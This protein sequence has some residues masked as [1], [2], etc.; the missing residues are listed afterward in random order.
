MRLSA[1][2]P[3]EASVPGAPEGFLYACLLGIALGA[4]YDIFRILRVGRGATGGDTAPV[5]R[6]RAYR[7]R[8]L[9]H[10]P[11]RKKKRTGKARGRLSVLLVFFEDILFC[12]I[13]A[14]VTTLFFFDCN[15]GVIRWYLLMGLL[16]GFCAY[17]FSVGKA[18]IRFA[19]LICAAVR[20]VLIAGYNRVLYYPLL[21]ITEGVYHT[22]RGAAKLR[23][24][25]S[26]ATMHARLRRYTE[27]QLKQDRRLF[28]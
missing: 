7:L 23:K 4:V 16:L 26:L 10:W 9:A 14:V 11:K 6:L 19:A 13:C 27:K 12:L 21:W 15:M 28:E 8:E 17:Y 3:F 1:V 20:A 22:F 5:R 25:W 18:V 24:L 2:R